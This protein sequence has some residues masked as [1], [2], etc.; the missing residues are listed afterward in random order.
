MTHVLHGPVE[1]LMRAVAAEIMMPRFRDL[2][3]GEIAEKSPGDYV[4]VVDTLSEARITEA[5]TA[6]LP[7]SIVVGEEAV[8]A[9]PA[10]VTGVTAP[11]AWIVDPLDGT[12]NFAAGRTPF[13]IMIALAADGVIEAGW[14]LDPVTDR[15]CSATRGKGA[16]V[17]GERVT[18]RPTGRKL[19]IGGLA[20]RY[21]PEDIRADVDARIV[22]RIESVPVAHCAGEQYP[23][24]VLGE[25][26]IA[27]FWRSMPWD[28]APGALFLE[29]AGGRIA[30]PNGDPYRV[31][32]DRVGLLAAASSALW[33]EAAEILFG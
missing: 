12:G 29:E 3:A 9:D 16:F 20:T 26:D 23:R 30:R 11:L 33:D 5:L 13:A 15:L 17:N 10:S 7:G 27:L 28:H 24:L 14:I 32:D 8:A 6:L 22:G 19:P 18:A 21:L 4:T 25:N 1:A 31:G 2:A